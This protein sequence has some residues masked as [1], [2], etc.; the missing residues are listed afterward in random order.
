MIQY[1]LM[2]RL[3][4]KYM[5]AFQNYFYNLRPPFNEENHTIGTNELVHNHSK[6]KRWWIAI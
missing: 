5:Q 2:K 4:G 6:I 3:F 1:W